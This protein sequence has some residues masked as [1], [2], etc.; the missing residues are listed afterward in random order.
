MTI[1]SKLCLLL[2]FPALVVLGFGILEY[3]H[4]ARVAQEMKQFRELADLAVRISAYVHETQKER[5]RTAMYLGADRQKFGRELVAQ[6]TLTNGR[7][8]ELREAL[9]GFDTAAHGKQFEELISKGIGDMD[10]LESMRADIS[11][12][13]VPAGEAIAFYTVMNGTLFDAIGAMTPQM[14]ESELAL[15]NYAYVT[16]LKSKERSGIER[17]LLSATFARDNFA[18][19]IYRKVV[20]LITEQDLF[21]NEFRFYA[22]E[23][24]NEAL[25]AAM[26]DPS[27]KKVEAYRAIAMEKATT[28]GFGVSPGDWFNTITQKINQLKKAEDSLSEQLRS[29][30]QQKF[31]AAS[32]K[33]ILGLALCALVLTGLIVGGAYVARSIAKPI[34]LMT[35]GAKQIIQSLDLT[36]R[37]DLQSKD[38]LG[39]FADQFDHFIEKMHEVIS[40]VASAATDVASAS[41]EIAASSDQMANGMGEQSGQLVQISS[42]I[43]QMASSVT[44]VARKSSDAAQ[45]AKESGE[46]AG[47]GQHTVQE[48]VEGMTAINDA[49]SAS[50]ASVQELGKRGEEI[51]QIIDVINDIAGQTN[52]LAL[53]AAIEAAR[54]GEHGRGFAVV[55]DEV[56]KLADRTTS[57]TEEISESIKAIQSETTE[58]VDRM[59]VGTEH[60]QHGVAKANVAGQSLEQIVE[61]ARDVTDMIQS[62]AAA[63]E[64]Q[65]S[66]SEEIS[67]NV[68]MIS[69]V[70]AQASEGASQAAE[71]STQ[72]AER[73]E[74]LQSLVKRFKL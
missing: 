50:A 27:F 54:A 38:E 11:D 13:R 61:K 4:A 60:V 64:E 51:G 43:E 39:V 10:R 72:L 16:F 74:S 42:A 56:R 68:D 44:E 15:A 30:A 65:S 71:A 49:V 12:G 59:R 35:D 52:L 66:T 9:A 58:A 8:A 22:N 26:D 32:R 67:R 47:E 41:T 37:I 63:A 19:G 33:K 1:R 6:R 17:A 69:N 34:G 20:S 40:D 70:T 2:A 57:A 55:A 62:I 21:L 28:G 31:V 48:T 23:K 53:N 73:S 24:A 25:T 18:P 36:R 46:V 7:L 3:W 29:I 5:G 14:T 45:N